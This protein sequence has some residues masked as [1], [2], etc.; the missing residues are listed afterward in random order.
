MDPLPEKWKS[1]GWNTY[2]INGHN[3]SQIKKALLSAKK[4]S[5]K[6]S[7]LVCNTVKGKGL[8]GFEDKLMSHYRPPSEEQLNDILSKS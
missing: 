1:F 4:S 5:Q 7:V 2:D 3:S 6:P 8:K